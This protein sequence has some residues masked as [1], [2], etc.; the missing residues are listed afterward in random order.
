MCTSECYQGFCWSDSGFFDAAS[1]LIF[2]RAPMREHHKP[3]SQLGQVSYST[4]HYFA[5]H[6]QTDAPTSKLG[7]MERSRGVSVPSYN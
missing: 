5:T 7:M 6:N 4:L 3:A 2:T 1:Q